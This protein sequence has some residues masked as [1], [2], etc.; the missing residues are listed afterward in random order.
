[1]VTGA[2]AGIV[3]QDEGMLVVHVIARVRPEG[4]EDVLTVTLADRV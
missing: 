3:Y 1:M 2:G 4:V